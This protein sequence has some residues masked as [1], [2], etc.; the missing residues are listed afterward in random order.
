VGLV[1]V[2]PDGTAYD[3]TDGIRSRADG[4]GARAASS[5]G[6]RAGSIPAEVGGFRHAVAA[7]LD[8]GYGRP[9]ANSVLPGVPMPKLS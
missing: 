4:R 3:V 5:A 9:N 7:G 1:D 2:E 8:Q 6:R